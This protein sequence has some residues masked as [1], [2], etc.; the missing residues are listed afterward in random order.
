MKSS[1]RAEQG[2]A[3]GAR[4]MGLNGEFVEKVPFPSV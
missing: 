2:A 4:K 1:K 3:G